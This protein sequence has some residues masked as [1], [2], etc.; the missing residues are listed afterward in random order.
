[1]PFT[2]AN[3]SSARTVS[4]SSLAVFS[5]SLAM[6]CEPATF[7]AGVLGLVEPR[8][9]SRLYVTPLTCSTSPCSMV[10]N[11]MT[12]PSAGDRTALGLGSRGRTPGLRVR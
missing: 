4:S 8:R 12:L 5:C 2:L 7:W 1:M 9:A 11:W 10:P 3:S 6:T